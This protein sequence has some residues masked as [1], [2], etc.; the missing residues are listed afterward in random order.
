MYI[1]Q[2]C[3]AYHN[4]ELPWLCF[5]HVS[6]DGKAP[7]TGPESDT[8]FKDARQK[9]STC[10]ACGI[11]GHAETLEQR[12]HGLIRFYPP[13]HAQDF[14]AAGRYSEESY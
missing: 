10:F 2:E 11:V 14:V 6:V 3:F 1:C 8:W 13:K 9:R 4:R 5:S 12:N 7:K